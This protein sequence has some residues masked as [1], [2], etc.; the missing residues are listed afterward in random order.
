[1]NDPRIAAL[2]LLREWGQV[3]A[4]R[5]LSQCTLAVRHVGAPGGRRPGTPPQADLLIHAPAEILRCIRHHSLPQGDWAN[6]IER[7]L[8]AALHPRI[9]V[10]DIQWTQTEPARALRPEPLGAAGGRGRA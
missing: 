10:R 4:A 9:G 6:E 1:M 8:K 5:A 3:D 7:A 2:E